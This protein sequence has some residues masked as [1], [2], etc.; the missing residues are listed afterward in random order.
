VK[1]G[2][3]AN[4]HGETSSSKGN[5]LHSGCSLAHKSLHILHPHRPA[6]KMHLLCTLPCKTT[7]ALKVIFLT[8]RDTGM[9]KKM[10]L[11]KSS[12]KLQDFV[13]KDKLH[14]PIGNFTRVVQSHTLFP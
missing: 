7:E 4:V 2:D 5:Q 14:N 3:S 6:R 13:V 10:E 12:A 9:R 8:K 1:T 11:K